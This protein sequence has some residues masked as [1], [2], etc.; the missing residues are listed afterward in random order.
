VFV[1]PA[2]PADCQVLCCL[3][4]HTHSVTRLCVA[5]VESQ[6]T[7][8]TCNASAVGLGLCA[9]AA[10][11]ATQQQQ[12][13]G[14]NPPAVPADQPTAGQASSSAAAAAT[15]NSNTQAPTTQ[16]NSS[17]AAAAAAVPAAYDVPWAPWAFVVAHLTG[18]DAV[19]TVGV[20][21]NSKVCHTT[22]LR[23]SLA[24]A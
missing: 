12:Q 18:R 19:C 4:H 3:A 10:L 9:A 13:A 16:Q 8:S 24:S 22:C 6:H 20:C 21:L 2:H 17:A 14:P 23:S 11:A 15:P 7:I 5:A 1:P